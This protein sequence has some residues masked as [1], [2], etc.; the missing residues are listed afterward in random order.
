M[1]YEA[2]IYIFLICISCLFLLIREKVYSSVLI[3]Y[4]LASIFGV[5]TITCLI[6]GKC[7][8]EVYYLIITYALINILFIFYYPWLR[9]HFPKISN[10][11]KNR[12][13]ENKEKKMKLF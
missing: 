1:I 4:F 2:K 8:Q 3:T 11:I 7:Y 12:K 13:N 6:K 9:K 5:R 10:Y